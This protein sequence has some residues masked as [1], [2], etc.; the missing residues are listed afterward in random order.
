MRQCQDGSPVVSSKD[1]LIARFLRL[2]CQEREC[3][4]GRNACPS[5][6]DRWQ[7]LPDYAISLCLLLLCC[8]CC[9]RCG[10]CCCCYHIWHLFCDF[11]CPRFRA[12]SQAMH[13]I[14]YKPTRLTVQAISRVLRRSAED[15]SHVCGSASQIQVMSAHLLILGWS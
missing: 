2:G 10:C 4:P 5:C 7:G 1:L 11:G 12:F 3:Y 13:L 15:H 14:P 6:I 8:C 9:R